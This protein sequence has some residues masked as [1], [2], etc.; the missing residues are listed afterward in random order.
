M[1][2]RIFSVKKIIFSIIFGFITGFIFAAGKVLDNTDSIDF[3]QIAMYEKWTIIMI[4][5]SLF[6]F[7]A[8]ELIDIISHKI[9][10]IDK[11]IPMWLA[12]VIMIV[13]WVPTWFSIFPGA[14]NYDAYDEWMMV[15]NGN[16][17][18]HHPVI[19]VIVLGGLVE[20]ANK[21]W[22]SYNAGIAI[23]TVIQMCLL[24]FIFSIAIKK[25]Q[26]WNCGLVIQIIAL[27]FYALSPVIQL[28]SVAATKDTIFNG[29]ELLFFLECIDI[30]REKE[31][32][33]ANN[34][35]LIRLGIIGFLTM[36]MRNNGVYIVLFALIVIFISLFSKLTLIWKK[37]LFLC[38]M[39]LV[40]YILF[41]GPIYSIFGITGAKVQEKLAVPMQQL[42]RVYNYEKETLSNDEK[43]KILVYF[44]EESLDA[45]KSTVSDIV[46]MGFNNE[47]YDDDTI[48]FYKLWLELGRKHPFIYVSSFLINTVDGWYP[49]A[50]VDGYRFG[51]GRSSYF[52]YKVAE[53]G[54][55]AVILDGLNSK[56]N[57]ISNDVSSQKGLLFI[58]LLS[59]GTYLLFFV[60]TW[61]YHASRGNY[62]F[63]NA[64]LMQVIHYATVL[65]GPIALVRYE[66]NFFYIFPIIIGCFLVNVNLKDEKE[67]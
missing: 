7:W 41:I 32:Y 16:V 27:L 61:L 58:L 67:V 1:I 46:K 62:C 25:L 12:Y 17:T 20:L 35:A 2:K 18:A 6:C 30:F 38:L 10:R 3:K 13:A 9:K 31:A 37:A 63:V 15:A 57:Y 28:F 53:P 43:E 48:G 47:A 60:F 64:G 8:W 14:F 52:D 4:V 40:P 26:K 59:P 55:S 45:Y 36:I 56:W 33:F 65:V 50:V 11:N 19:H 66:L 44:S 22:G 51:D 23:Y 21:I 5:T 34:K 54:N 24:S 29:L 49:G 42:A 39:L